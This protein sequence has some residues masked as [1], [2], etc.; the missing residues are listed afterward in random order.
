LKEG[1]EGQPNDVLPVTRSKQEAK[2]NYNR[3]SGAYDYLSGPFEHRH[4]AKAVELLSPAGGELVLEIGFG[5]GRALEEITGLVGDEVE[6]V[7][8]DLSSGMA[9]RTRSRLRKAGIRNACLSI[10][11][12]VNLPYREQVMGS[13]LISFTLELFDTPEIPLVLTGTR[14]VLKPGGKLAVVCLSKET[15]EPLALK[16]YE[17]GHRKWPALID[18]RPIYGER[19][20]MEAGFQIV[21]AEKPRMMGLPLEI[22]VAE[23]SKTGPALC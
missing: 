11:D 2:K 12:A 14:R 22:V 7:G 5:T 13:T 16:L 19:S 21:E 4:T 15:G 1:R 8:L 9:R 20:V 17:W 18:C 3:L 10:G 23:K 6:V